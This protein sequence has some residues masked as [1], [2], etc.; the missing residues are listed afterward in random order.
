[1]LDYACAEFRKKCDFSLRVASLFKKEGI[2]RWTD[3]GGTLPEKF[4]RCQNFSEMPKKSGLRPE[5]KGVQKSKKMSFF[6]IKNVKNFESGILIFFF[7][8]KFQPTNAA[9]RGLCAKGDFKVPTLKSP[10]GRVTFQE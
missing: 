6:G 1:M 8:K 9:E 7:S 3:L 10:K 4:F 2:F 5:N